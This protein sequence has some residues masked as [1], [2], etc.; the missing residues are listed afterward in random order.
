V[1]DYI[2]AGQRSPYRARITDIALHEFGVFGQ[3]FRDAVKMYLAREVVKNANVV[4]SGQQGVSQMRSHKPCSAGDEYV[5][6]HS[7]LAPIKA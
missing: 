5:F 2:D 6:C 7:Y 3:I 4:A 1:K